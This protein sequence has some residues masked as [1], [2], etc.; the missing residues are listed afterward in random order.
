MIGKETKV[1]ISRYNRS[2]KRAIENLKNI[3]QIEENKIIIKNTLNI[4]RAMEHKIL[5]N[6]RAINDENISKFIKG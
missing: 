1:L 2:V 6:N 3:E 5:V 4:S